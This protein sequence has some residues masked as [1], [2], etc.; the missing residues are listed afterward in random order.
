[1]CGGKYLDSKANEK[2]RCVGRNVGRLIGPIVELVVTEE[3]D[4][5]HEDSGVDVDSVERVEVI[6]TVRFREITVGVVQ[7]PLPTCR[8]GVVSRGGLR[9]QTK[10]CHDPRAIVDYMKIRAQ[11]SLLYAQLIGTKNF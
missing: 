6:S 5:R 2:P 8:A 10:L 3:A 7:V 1:M 9:I 11:T 4:I